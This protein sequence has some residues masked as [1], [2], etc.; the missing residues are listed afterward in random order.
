MNEFPKLKSGAIAQYPAGRRTVYSTWVGQFAGGGEQRFREY[1][2]ALRRWLI[3]L[4]MLS[5]R[6]VFAL[7]MF[8][9]GEQGRAGMFSFE[10]PWD[11]TVYENCSFE[12]DEHEVRWE[13]EEMGRTR[14]VIR[15]NR[16]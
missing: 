4:R 1:P 15:Q 5:A 16:I 3:D 9:A 10:D 13:G 11:G 7:R 12:S 6:E 8:F 14:I 2:G